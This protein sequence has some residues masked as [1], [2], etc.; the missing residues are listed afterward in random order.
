MASKTAHNP[1][2]NY[3]AKSTTLLDYV[4]QTI[5]N[6]IETTPSNIKQFTN[7][8]LYPKK[9]S[10]VVTLNIPAE[11]IKLS[12]RASRARS[13]ASKD[14]INRKLVVLMEGLWWSS[15]T[16]PNIRSYFILQT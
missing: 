5:S 13:Q 8:L 11:G 7:I 14:A 4:Y 16:N 15:S 6:P 10:H 2:H 12:A 9:E 3:V 1:S